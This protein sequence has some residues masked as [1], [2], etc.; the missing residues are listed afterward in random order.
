MQNEAYKHCRFRTHY[1][2]GK[3]VDGDGFTA[4]HLFTS[5]EIEIRLLGI[6]APEVKKCSKLIQDERELHLPGQLL[7]EL[8]RV[9]HRFLMELIQPEQPFSFYT[10]PANEKDMYG[11]TLAYVILPSGE[12]LNE[13][14]V[15]EGMAKPYS[16]SYC[17]QLPHYQKVSASARAEKK[18]HYRAVSHF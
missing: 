13:V 3:V 14:L 10:E 11:R 18:G 1:K 7:I 4:V 16:K 9:S 17:S 6:D 5:E 15:K 2:V 8:G 12:C